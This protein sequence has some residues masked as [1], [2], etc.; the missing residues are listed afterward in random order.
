M[1]ARLLTA[2]LGIGR[3]TAREYLERAKRVGLSWPLPYGLTDDA[4]EQ[5]L[6]PMDRK[7]GEP[8]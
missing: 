6:F 2:G 1:L 8:G 5:R 4:L 3:T 7:S